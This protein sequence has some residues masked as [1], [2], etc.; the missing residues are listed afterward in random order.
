MGAPLRNLEF[1]IEDM[2]QAIYK[3]AEHGW[4][5]DEQ[6]FL[7]SSKLRWRS[8]YL[9]MRGDQTHDLAVVDLC[10]H[11]EKRLLKL[12]ILVSPRPQRIGDL[13]F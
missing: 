5:Q 7:R 9:G 12:D 3:T 1:S 8:C 13:F 4:P 11:T 6:D 10:Y 2:M